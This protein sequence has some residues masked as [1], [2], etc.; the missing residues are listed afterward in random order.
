MWQIIV[1]TEVFSKDKAA[2]YK[3]CVEPAIEYGT[4]AW[5]L[6]ESKTEFLQGIE[7]D[8]MRGKCGVQVKDRKRAKDLMLMFGLNETIDHLTIGYQC[9]LV[10]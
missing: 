3:N 10:W 1:R 7:R 4:E 9:V 6:K 2:V 8:I 5:C